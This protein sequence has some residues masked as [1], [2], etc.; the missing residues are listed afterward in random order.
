L[1]IVLF[2]VTNKKVSHLLPCGSL[3]TTFANV[4]ESSHDG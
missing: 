1:D 4:L 3:T 2:F